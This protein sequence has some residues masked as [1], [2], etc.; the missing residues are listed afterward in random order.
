MTWRGPLFV[1]A[2]FVFVIGHSWATNHKQQFAEMRAEPDWRNCKP[3]TE[4]VDFLVRRFDEQIRGIGVAG[5]DRVELWLGPA[6]RTW[7][8]VLNTPD[9]KACVLAF[10][11]TWA[12]R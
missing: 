5:N 3:R 12:K 7:T 6:G 4:V 11:E 2:M 1:L 9:G 10:G 8:L